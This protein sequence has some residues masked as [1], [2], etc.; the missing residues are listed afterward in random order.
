MTEQYLSSQKLNELVAITDL[1]D[2]YN[3]EEIWKTITTL[4]NINCCN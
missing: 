4:C 2:S 3:D 1:T